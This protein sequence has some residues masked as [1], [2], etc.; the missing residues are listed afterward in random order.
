MSWLN[1]YRFRI[2]ILIGVSVAFAWILPN[3][4]FD[5]PYSTVV[6][7]SQG[8]LLGAH[9][10][11]DGQWRFPLSDSVPDR[12]ASSLL[13]FEDEYF[14]W[15]PGVNPV[16]LSRALWSN[17]KSGRV[18]SGGS[19]LTMQVIRLSRENP[20]RTYPEKIWE[21]VLAMRLEW[22]YSKDEIL[23]LYAAHAPFGGNVVG[24]EA[25]SWRYYGKPAEKLTWAES[26]T[27][28][29]LPNAPSM[30]YPGKN[31]EPLARKR[32]RLLEK[33]LHNEVIDSN[34][35]SLALLEPIPERPQPLPRR[36]AHLVDR[37]QAIHEGQTLRST[38]DPYLQDQTNEVL[39]Q[40]A[41]ENAYNHIYNL[42]ALV[43]EV[44]TGEVKA[45][46]GNSKDLQY[47]HDNWVDM[48]GARRS[49]GSLLK[50]FLFAAM[51]EDGKMTPY[52]LVDD[53]PVNFRGYSPKNFNRQFEGV[54]PADHALNRS[55]NVPAVNE[56]QRY[57]V[58]RFYQYL[59]SWGMR[60]LDFPSDHYG[61]S[62]IL[63]GSE[64]TLENLSEM[65]LNLARAVQEQSPEK[66]KILPSSAAEN[67]N[68]KPTLEP[69]LAWFTTQALVGV[70]DQNASRKPT[71]AWKTGTSF[72][73]RDAWAIGYNPQYVI[74]VWL[75]NADGEGRPG[76]TGASKAVPLMMK[77]AN[78]IPEASWFEMPYS[79]WE[80]RELCLH[81]GLPKSENCRSAESLPVPRN[82]KEVLPCHY[83]HRY[84]TDTL[85]ERRYNRQCL[86][87]GMPYAWHSY[88]Q[89]SPVREWYY[90][91]F[92]GDYE[93]VPALARVCT[94]ERPS[95]PM[96]L[97][98]PDKHNLKI[99]IPV[100]VDGKLGKVV[101]QAVHRNPEST[102][103]W[104]LGDR[105]L[106]ETQGIHQLS[107]Q[108]EPGK[109]DL[110]LLDA[111]GHEIRRTVEIL[112]K[113]SN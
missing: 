6:L 113:E 8:G 26:A 57:G 33:L 39:N 62:L 52:S 55:L 104:H 19:T 36:A 18:K 66:L 76:L 103:F 96:G 64:G 90:S 82:M 108:P 69:S 43:I 50:P 3:P 13:H 78:F 101:F 79:G 109:Y 71:L 14:Y 77:I 72:G 89:L 110:V 23:Q 68:L 88:F 11:R 1:K 67:T 97:I 63:G 4:L 60:T 95:N 41:E 98:F 93:R 70:R 38:L 22:S 2:A 112:G 80:E 10:A 37:L 84:L 94:T 58:E 107:L 15:H 24:L 86:P 32:N 21:M 7:D 27:L 48:V 35:F 44:S 102:I 59:S 75:G 74:G 53:I 12:F 47:R 51:L 9:T 81:S 65:Y 45:Y 46:V 100:E 61:L 111:E 25:A 87:S 56:L 54:V 34:E 99:Y 40:V 31:R 5:V 85:G 105:Y 17:I 92:H 91:Q 29:V 49:T 30:I 28:A 20:P 106:G 16:S 83:C 42:S 73:N